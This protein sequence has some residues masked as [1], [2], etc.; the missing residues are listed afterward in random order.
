MKKIYSILF[1]LICV[2]FIGKAQV[3]PG[4]CMVTV[5]DS[6]KHNIVYTVVR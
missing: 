5:D 2:A 4:I 3:L 1:A 6:S